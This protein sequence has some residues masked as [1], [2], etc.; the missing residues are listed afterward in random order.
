MVHSCHKW[1]ISIVSR[2]RLLLIRISFSWK[3]P[4]FILRI[5]FSPLIYL[6]GLKFCTIGLII[7]YLIIII[8]RICWRH[9]Y[10]FSLRRKWI[11]RRKCF[12]GWN[13]RILR[14]LWG[15]PR[16]RIRRIWL[17][18]LISLF[19]EISWIRLCISLQILLRIW[20]GHWTEYISQARR[21]TRR[22]S[23]SRTQSTRQT[24]CFTTF[25]W[26]TS[27]VS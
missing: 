22:K 20:S 4:C 9:F 17:C 25:Q 12:W 7:K 1:V 24:R 2:T 26:H 27:A 16:D 8:W 13:S 14:R 15:L 6:K 21:Q 11:T 18:K 10:I 3:W 5:L 19:L 23:T